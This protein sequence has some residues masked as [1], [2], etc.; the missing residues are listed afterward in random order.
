ML[1]IKRIT[2]DQ[3]EKI[4][5]LEKENNPPNT[6]ILTQEKMVSLFDR[7]FKDEEI[8]PQDLPHIR[9]ARDEALPNAAIE[10]FLFFKLQERCN[11]VTVRKNTKF[12][13]KI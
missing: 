12:A 8:L 5:Q 7:I 4:Q 1:F 3:L 6:I 2:P 10:V 11:Q 13:R 9:K